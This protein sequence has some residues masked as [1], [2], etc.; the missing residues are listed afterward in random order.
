MGFYT[1]SAIVHGSVLSEDDKD[2]VLQHPNF[3]P[4]WNECIYE[5]ANDYWIVG[6]KMNHYQFKDWINSVLETHELEQGWVSGKEIKA[7]IENDTDIDI[8][9]V[10]TEQQTDMVNDIIAFLRAS[11]SCADLKT[12]WLFLEK[13]VCTMGEEWSATPSRRLVMKRDDRE[14]DLPY[15]AREKEEEEEDRSLSLNPHNSSYRHR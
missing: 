1:L 6:S 13:T 3:K 2:R 10:L 5:F 9:V 15:T 12:Y 11:E 14:E 7:V 8:D 4:E